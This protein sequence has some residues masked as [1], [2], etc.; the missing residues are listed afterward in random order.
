MGNP[1][2]RPVRSMAVIGVVPNDH[3]PVS[4]QDRRR[5]VA[6]WGS[7]VVELTRVSMTTSVPGGPC[8]DCCGPLHHFSVTA[9][10]EKV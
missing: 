1:L 2:A 5:E 9:R 10:E 3:Q 7:S 8:A 4:R 6:G